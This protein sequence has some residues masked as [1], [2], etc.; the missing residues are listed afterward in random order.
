M[1]RAYCSPPEDLATVANDLTGDHLERPCDHV[2]C[3]G[4]HDVWAATARAVLNALVEGKERTHHSISTLTYSLQFCCELCKRAD[5]V[6]A[7]WYTSPTWSKSLRDQHAMQ[8]LPNRH[9]STRGVERRERER[10]DLLVFK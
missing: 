6:L 2:W 5:I 10:L 4:F 8:Q 3:Q 7:P 1:H 9:L